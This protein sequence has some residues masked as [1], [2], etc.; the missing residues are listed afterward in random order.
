M[1]QSLPFQVLLKCK[2]TSECSNLNINYLRIIGSVFQYE[3]Q[4]KVLS[5]LIYIMPWAVDV[6]KRI[7]YLEI[8]A[9]FKAVR[10]YSYCIFHGIKFNNSIPFAISEFPTEKEDLYELLF[11]GTSHFKINS[12]YFERK[13]ALSDL[14][15]SILSFSRR[16]LM[17]NHF[18]HRHIIEIFGAITGFG[19]W[20]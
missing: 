5:G 12:N 20:V 4:A 10:P 16:H 15:D 19:F 9:S 11:E 14:G 6:A 13:H 18:C 1:V 7:D 2:N 17:Q 3:D 8:D